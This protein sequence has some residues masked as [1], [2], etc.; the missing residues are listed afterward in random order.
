M[1]KVISNQDFFKS[2]CD[3]LKKNQKVSLIIKGTSMLPFFKDGK[4]EVFL[5]SKE[6]YQKKDVCLFQINDRYVLHRLIKI[7][8]QKY[9]FRGDHLCSYEIVRK[10]DIIAY[11][12]QYSKNN[13]MIQSDAM[14][15]RLK[16]W[17][18]LYYH[19]FKC[20]LKRIYRGVR[21]GNQ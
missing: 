20:F 10:E 7:N 21:H 12:Y 15:H 13:Q 8:N 18:Y 2:I 3:D 14:S 17:V 6:T 1:K 5:K 16:R 19:Q 11:V 4:T 9:Y